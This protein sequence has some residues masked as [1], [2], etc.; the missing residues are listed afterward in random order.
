MSTSIEHNPSLEPALAPELA[1]KLALALKALDYDS[2]A[3]LIALLQ[4]NLGDNISQ[5]SLSQLAPKRWRAMTAKLGGTFT[6]KQIDS[7]YSE[8]TRCGDAAPAPVATG[9]RQE[10]PSV[11]VAV[12][13]NNGQ[14]LDGHFGSCLRVLVYQVTAE[15]FQLI[16][17]RE[18]ESDTKGEERAQYLVSKIADCDLLFTLSIGGPAAAKV[19]R[20]GVHPIK[21]KQ[22]IPADDKL[23]Q[24][25]DKLK[26]GFPRWIKTV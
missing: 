9:A 12:T 8:L 5:H 11:I 14:E 6:R 17:V 10:T 2:P 19:T 23:T 7:A 26:V 15:D 21:V 18:I 24:L 16:E 25:S 22:P 20:A 13:S 4:A 1:H 3:D